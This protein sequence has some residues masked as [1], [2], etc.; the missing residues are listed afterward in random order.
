MRHIQTERLL[1][2]AVGAGDA[3]ALYAIFGDPETNRYNP[4]G[5]YPSPEHARMTLAGWTEEWER[6]GFGRWAVADK[7]EP[8]RIIGFGG[9]NYSDYGGQDRLSLGY[10][11][12]PS[13]WGRGLASEMARQAL[14]VRGPGRACRVRQGPSGQSAL[15]PSVAAAGLQP[16]RQPARHS[17][18]AGVIG[19]Y[20]ACASQVGRHEN[21][22]PAIGGL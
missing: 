9:L 13:A 6:H 20:F 17:R 22:K 14:R 19:L 3:E 11:F 5:P 12:A 4:H 18:R 10:R 7:E 1:L 2:R 21:E 15:D 16:S 8:N